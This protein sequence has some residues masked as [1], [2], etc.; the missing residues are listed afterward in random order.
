VLASALAEHPTSRTSDIQ[1]F[2]ASRIVSSL[3]AA[4]PSLIDPWVQE[5]STL[6]L[7]AI[8]DGCGDAMV[9][10][11]AQL[12]RFLMTHLSAPESPN[13]LRLKSRVWRHGPLDD[14]GAQGHLL[15]HMTEVLLSRLKDKNRCVQVACCSAFGAVIEEIAGDLM[16]PYLEPVFDGL[17]SALG[18]Y[19]R[20]SLLIMFG[21]FGIIA[22]FVGA[23]VGQGSLPDL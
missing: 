7:G 15:V 18:H 3:L 6:A 11:M 2:C 23:A 9:P 12:H 17:V 13:T 10:H 4:S 20:R 8:A 22:D 19:P 5:A 14:M 21:A 1:F 16:V